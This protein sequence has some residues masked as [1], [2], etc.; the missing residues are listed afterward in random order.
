MNLQPGLG[1]FI[2]VFR[3]HSST[4]K[5][6]NNTAVVKSKTGAAS[7][8][9][10][11]GVAFFVRSWRCVHQVRLIRTVSR[12]RC[13]I[14]IQQQQQ[15]LSMR[16]IFN[17]H[18]AG[19]FVTRPSVAATRQ[20]SYFLFHSKTTKCVRCACVSVC[21][22]S[23]Y[24]LGVWVNLFSAS[25]RAAAARERSMSFIRYNISI[26]YARACL[27]CVSSL[28]TAHSPTTLSPVAAAKL[29]VTRLLCARRVCCFKHTRA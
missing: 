28:T 15:N 6:K 23:A 16:R 5:K 4:Q 2:R 24:A 3:E 9:R 27:M 18:N 1:Q 7:D 26:R 19:R 25:C 29:R 8:R 14:N 21:N 17:V 11:R 12:S 13:T 20:C 22:L 10:H